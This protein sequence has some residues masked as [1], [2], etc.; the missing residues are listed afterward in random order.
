MQPARDSQP[1]SHSPAQDEATRPSSMYGSLA[2]MLIGLVLIAF[3][4]EHSNT[5]G[6]IFRMPFELGFGY[7]CFMWAF[8]VAPPPQRPVAV[9]LLVFATFLLVSQAYGLAMR[10]R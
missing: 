3:S 9:A 4:I 2:L 5:K 1:A 7:G 6:P 10:G 8:R